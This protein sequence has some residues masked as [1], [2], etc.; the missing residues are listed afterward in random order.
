LAAPHG[1]TAQEQWKLGS[2]GAPGSALVKMG[3]AVASGLTEA[4]GASFVVERQYIGNEQEMVQQVLRGRIQAGATSAQ[5]LGVAVP[6]VTV[7]AFPYLWE[8]TE[9][10][11]HVIENEVKG[12]IDELM[13][14]KGLKLL[15]IG[16]AGYY[17]VFC[18][19]DCHDP[20]TLVGTKVRVSPTPAANLF[21]TVR[22]ANGVQM[23]ISELWPGLEQNLVRAAD[24]PFGFYLTTPAV[25]SAPHFVDTRHFHAPWIFFMNKRLWDGM[26]EATQAAVMESLPSQEVLLGAYQEELASAREK[27]AG[28]NGYY[29]ELDEATS[30]KWRDGVEARMPELLENMGPGARKLYEAIQAAKAAYNEANPG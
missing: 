14:E 25:E 16:D 19:F 12:I 27:F 17:G 28:M 2:V 1:A 7:L 30:A 13:A 6:D 18:Q 22:G 24:I 8:S 9:Q 26:D 4:G 21:W 15:A 23:P 5:G 11:D 20:E 29:Y 3:D 10:R